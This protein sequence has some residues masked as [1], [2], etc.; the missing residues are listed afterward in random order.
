MYTYFLSLL[1]LGVFLKNGNEIKNNALDDHHNSHTLNFF[2][3]V[4][5]IFLLPPPPL[6]FFPV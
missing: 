5:F 1:L 6:V 2:C 3:M 4:S